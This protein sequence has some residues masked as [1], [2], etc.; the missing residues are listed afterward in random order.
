MVQDTS[1]FQVEDAEPLLVRLHDVLPTLHRTVEPVIAA[2]RLPGVPL[3]EGTV[4]PE[5]TVLL[6]HTTVMGDSVEEVNRLLAP[7]DAG[8]LNERSSVTFAGRPQS[9]PKMLRR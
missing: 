2:T 7:L 1:T 3:G 9:P 5:G 4:R 8:A 6:L